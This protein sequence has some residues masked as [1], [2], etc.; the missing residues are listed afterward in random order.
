[1]LL[2]SSNIR[3]SP[4]YKTA[5]SPNLGLDV[6]VL[7]GL[8]SSPWLAPKSHLSFQPL[9]TKLNHYL[10]LVL[11]LI[12]LDVHVHPICVGKG[13]HVPHHRQA[14]QSWGLHAYFDIEISFDTNQS[15][16]RHRRHQLWVHFLSCCFVSIPAKGSGP[17]RLLRASPES[18]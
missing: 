14:F 7:R 16:S 3:P 1:M 15:F 17:E 6:L 9:N 12:R 5:L 10:V 18:R 8:D 2:S 4:G 13:K 11:G